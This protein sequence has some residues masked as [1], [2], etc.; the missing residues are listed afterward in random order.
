M[1]SD[2]RRT[3]LFT[4]Q[5]STPALGMLRCVVGFLLG[6]RF[7]RIG[8]AHCELLC[9]ERFQGI[10]CPC[11]C[12]S[13]LRSRVAHERPSGARFHVAAEKTGAGAL[14]VMTCRRI[15]ALRTEGART[16][17]LRRLRDETAVF[18][19]RCRYRLLKPRNG[20]SFGAGACGA[21]HFPELHHPLAV[22]DFPGSERDERRARSEPP[23]LRQRVLIPKV[24]AADRREPIRAFRWR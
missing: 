10:R 1:S 24:I 11:T 18:D 21:G 16:F 13:R 20:A 22:D 8:S 14:W 17:G 2:F 5:A 23:P 6:L 4:S 15:L 12:Y 19:L 3:D 7:G 9:D